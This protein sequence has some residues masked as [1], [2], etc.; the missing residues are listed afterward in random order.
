MKS[1]STYI[2]NEYCAITVGE[3]SPMAC[4]VQSNKKKNKKEWLKSIIKSVQEKQHACPNS[5]C[6]CVCV[7]FIKVLQY[8]TVDK[9]HTNLHR[10]SP[11][12]TITYLL[13]LAYM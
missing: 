10:S 8:T 3:G 9:S 12:F 11:M 6:V 1:A 5:V 13:F 2:A 7:C 4:L